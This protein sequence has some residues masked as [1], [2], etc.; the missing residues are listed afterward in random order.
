MSRQQLLEA[1][2]SPRAVERMT[3]DWTRLARGIYLMTDMPAEPIW[4]AK[5]WTGVLLGGEGARAG[6]MTAA[7][8]LGLAEPA[9]IDQ[10]DIL[11]P[12]GRTV[13][14]HPDIRFH[15]ERSGVRLACG[16]GEP[17][18]TRAEDTTLDLCAAGTPEEAVAWLT[19]A[20]QMRLST[21]HRLRR[22]LVERARIRHRDTML[23]ILGDVAEGAT[24]VLER[25]AL[26]DVLR[27]HGLPDYRLQHRTQAQHLVDAVFE[28]YRVAAEFDGKLGHI[29][30]GAFRDARRD[31]A[32][33]ID[34]WMTLRFGWVDVVGDPCQVAAIIAQVLLSRGWA[35]PFGPCPRCRTDNGWD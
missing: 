3:S 32:H 31:N 29:G 34:G 35:G 19:R 20:C 7:A 22:R 21:P 8:L 5:V 24:T 16:P 15:R 11:I 18:R 6:G 30:Q 4:T 25:R 1:G 23:Q 10:M 13:T 14:A 28:R 26:L 17:P 9:E 2:V 12:H 33:A 27:P